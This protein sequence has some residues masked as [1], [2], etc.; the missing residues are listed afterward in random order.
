MRFTI[1]PK[2]A[3]PAASSGTIIITVPTGFTITAA[4]AACKYSFD[5]TNWIRSTACVVAF[6][7]VTLP[8][9]TG[10]DVPAVN[11]L[12][13]QVT[14]DDYALPVGVTRPTSSASIYTF[15][16]KTQVSGTTKESVFIPLVLNPVS[17]A[18]APTWITIGANDYSVIKVSFNAD[19]NYNPN[20]VFKFKYVTNN[21]LANMFPTS[22]GQA[23]PELRMLAACG[24]LP[25]S[26]TISANVLLKC[27]YV[28]GTVSPMFEAEIRVTNEKSVT[29]GATITFY[30]ANIQNPNSGNAG[31]E[32]TVS[33]P[34]R[35]DGFTCP[36]F[37]KRYYTTFGP[38]SPKTT[39][40]VTSQARPALQSP[41]LLVN[42]VKHTWTINL[43]ASVT[44]NDAFVAKIPTTLVYMVT[45]CTTTLGICINFPTIGWTFIQPTSTVTASATRNVD[46]VTDNAQ[47]YD[48]TQTL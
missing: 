27:Y 45:P 43:A 48:R 9:V 35:N 12:Y 21:E 1:A 4:T 46:A 8:I 40:P 20:D 17:L 41:N 7:S 13:L 47:F 39:V 3:L 42:N 15:N 18:F 33:R 34:C 14:T 23:V 19:Q 2:T 38:A 6:P 31:W 11:T 24:Q 16:I 44:A 30:I 22:L 10:F 37:H 36:I 25:T 5:N 28:Q 32:F 29:S 26:T